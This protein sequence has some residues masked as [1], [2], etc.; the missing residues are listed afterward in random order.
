MIA[1]GVCGALDGRISLSGDEEA[2][3]ALRAL[4]YT[5]AEAREALRKVPASIEKAS[6]RLREALRIVSG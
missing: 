2:L 6:E 3:Q 5:Q 4:G 1:G